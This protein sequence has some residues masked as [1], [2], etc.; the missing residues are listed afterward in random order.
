VRQQTKKLEEELAK[1]KQDYNQKLGPLNQEA[2]SLEALKSSL[3]YRLM[4]NQKSPVK[5]EQL[6]PREQGNGIEVNTPP[7]I[8]EDTSPKPPPI[9]PEDL[10]RQRKRTLADYVEYFIADSEREPI[11]QLLNAVLHDDRRDLGDMLELLSWGEIWTVRADWE[12]LE[13]QY[14][15]LQEWQQALSERLTYW[16]G[17]QR[18][19]E[20]TSAYGLWQEKRSRSPEEWL[21]YLE[22]LAQKQVAENERLA[23]EVA[24][25][26]QELQQREIE[27]K[28]G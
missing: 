11:L 25:L 3:K 26:E 1:V 24:I 4:Q 7:E 14:S 9:S 5:E 19:L 10:R 12:T 28:D 27:V 17:A 6:P 2:D 13:E 22:G 18:Q 20:T 23:H 16:Q 21:P 15:R 8:L